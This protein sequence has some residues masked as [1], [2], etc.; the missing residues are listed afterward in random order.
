MT[1]SVSGQFGLYPVWIFCVKVWKMVFSFTVDS[2]PIIRELV[3]L[4]VASLNLTLSISL[5]LIVIALGWIR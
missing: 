1:F 5:S 4:G 3:N 2:V